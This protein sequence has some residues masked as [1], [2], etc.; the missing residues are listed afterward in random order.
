MP[1]VGHSGGPSW[2]G[3]RLPG[4][5]KLAVTSRIFADLRSSGKGTFGQFAAG[6]PRGN[7][8]RRGTLPQ[9]SNRSDLS[10]GSRTNIGF[11]NP[12]SQVVTMRL[13]LRHAAGSLVRSSPLTLQSPS[14]QHNSITTS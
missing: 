4:A 11:F 12:T 14:R 6:A 3:P 1:A 9:L 13:V 8:L 7:A 2:G 5:A 10:S